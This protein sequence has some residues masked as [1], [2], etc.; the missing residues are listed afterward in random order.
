M[1]LRQ[2]RTFIHVAELG[3]FSKAAERLHIAQPALSRQV[4]LLEAELKAQLFVRHGRGVR[5]TDAGAVFL[6]R[7]ASILRQMEQ[8][9]DDVAAEAGAVSGQVSIGLPPSVGFVLTGPLVADFREAFPK[10][11][12]RIVEGVGGFVHEWLMGGRLDFAVLYKPESARHLDATPLWHED[13]H[14]IGPASAGLSPDGPVPL[15]DLA[16]YPVIL[17]SAGHGLRGLLERHAARHGVTLHVEI[18]ADAMRIQKDLTAR[19][20]GYTMLTYAAVRPEVEA[21]LLSA[22]PIVAPAVPRQ[23]VRAFPADRAV[24]R[25]ARLLGDRLTFVVRRMIAAGEWP[26]LVPDTPDL[27]GD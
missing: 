4:R 19:G 3:S 13:L 8:M 12:L 24:S 11:T 25:A 7:A 23:V 5:L 16:R 18:E 9:R 26:G 10:V 20:L 2:L 14:L 6:D 21:G 1:D 15:A 17:P 27:C 22:A